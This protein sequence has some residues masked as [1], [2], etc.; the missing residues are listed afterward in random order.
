MSNIQNNIVEYKYER[1]IFTSKKGNATTK[2]T[3]SLEDYLVPRDK[4]KDSQG[5]I[6]AEFSRFVVNI[7]ENNEGDKTHLKANIPVSAVPVICKKVNNAVRIADEMRMKGILQV[8]NDAET[9]SNTNSSSEPMII[10]LT[11]FK[12]MTPTQV[13][14]AN[15][16]NKKKLLDHI[17]I[18]EQNANKY[19]GNIKII[20]AI[21]NAV[22]MLDNGTLNGT[23]VPE[24]KIGE[25]KCYVSD[26]KYFREQRTIEGL[27]YNKCYQIAIEYDANM[28]VP[29][30][31]KICNCWCQLSSKEGGQTLI[32]LKTMK[33]KI[34]KN[35]RLSEEDMMDFANTLKLNLENFNNLYY[36][37]KKAL[38]EARVNAK[39]QQ[40]AASVS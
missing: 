24:K 17:P 15:P 33:D 31:I 39:R 38:T 16:A 23:A 28:R 21:N 10:S 19:K 1:D 7:L 40:Y 20:E 6:H 29:F 18:L 9:G 34:I 12:G 26:M 2:T 8:S 13:L 25:L 37:E 32:Q 11:E 36:G 30:V 22:A 27:A 5:L 3:L 35:Y 4:S 14:L